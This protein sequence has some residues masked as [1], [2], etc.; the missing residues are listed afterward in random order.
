MSEYKCNV[1]FADTVLTDELQIF[2]VT[3]DLV[4]TSSQ[5]WNLFDS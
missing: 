1:F 2:E 5:P 3:E 4:R